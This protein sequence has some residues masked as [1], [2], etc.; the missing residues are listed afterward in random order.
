MKICSLLTIS[1]LTI[2]LRFF[3]CKFAHSFNMAAACDVGQVT[4][5][6]VCDVP[7]RMRSS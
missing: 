3:T 7:R 6:T 1:F 2:Y 5:F 4:E